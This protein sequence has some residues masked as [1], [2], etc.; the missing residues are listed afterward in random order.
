MTQTEIGLKP[1]EPKWGNLTQ[2]CGKDSRNV[3]S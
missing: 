3:A 2:S 1:T